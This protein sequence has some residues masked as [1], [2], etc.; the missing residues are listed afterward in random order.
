MSKEGFQVLL[1]DDEADVLE[2]IS[3]LLET[4]IPDAVVLQAQDGAAALEIL[5]RRPVD[6]ILSD[7]RMPVMDGL[8]FLRQAQALRPDVPRLLITAYPDPQLAARAVRE[9]G[10][11]LF[12]AKPFNV[13]YLVEVLKAFRHD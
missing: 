5:R 7:Y 10:V 3:T 2:S 13:E 4:A 11:G 1:V 9:A 12:V 8:T 6:L